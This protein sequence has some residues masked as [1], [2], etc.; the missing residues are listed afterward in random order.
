MNPFDFLNAINQSKEDLFKDPQADKDYNAFIVNRGLSYFI[1]SLFFANKMNQYSSLDN[2]IQ[3]DFLRK[4]CSKKKRFSKWAT[5]SI[6][7]TDLDAICSYYGYSK[8]LAKTIINTFTEDQLQ[9]IREKF[10]KGGK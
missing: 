10:N 8:R 2:D 9:I 4:S 3:F 1:D 5:K 6:E 7:N